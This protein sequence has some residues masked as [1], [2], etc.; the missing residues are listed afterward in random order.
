MK[1][2]SGSDTVDLRRI[3]V[4]VA[5]PDYAL[6]WLDRFYD[7][8]DARLLE[9]LADGPLPANA[10]IDAVEGLDVAS[11]RRAHRR[12]VV[13][14]DDEHDL[15]SSVAVA[16]FWEHFTFWAT[17]AGWRDIPPEA[18]GPFGEG[19]LQHYVDSIAVGVADVKAGRPISDDTDYYHYVLFAEAEALVRAAARA[20]VR[21][22]VCRRTYQRCGTPTDVCIFLDDDERQ[23]GWEISR[24][25]ALELLHTAERAGLTFTSDSAEP[26]CASWIC[27]CCSDCCLPILSAARLDAT[28]IWPGR[29]HL[30]VIDHEVCSRCRACLKRCLFGAL[31]MDGK[32]KDGVLRLDETECRGCGVCATGCEQGALS[33][34]IREAPAPVRAA[35]DTD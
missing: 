5:A 33:M 19:Y 7:E 35:H 15:T 30:V 4:I 34:A 3:A 20:F 11:L 13:T 8:S 26:G 18:R 21:P 12:G 24:E 17:F 31:T 27:C 14:I 32:G 22:C 29:R 16:P 6:P 1:T 10:L 23:V 9:A 25:R 2:A 28:A